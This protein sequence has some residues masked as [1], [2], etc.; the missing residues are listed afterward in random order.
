MGIGMA[1]RG[2]R[3]PTCRMVSWRDGEWNV[4]CDGFSFVIR[5]GKQS[6]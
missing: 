3:S 2:T 4:L 6:G 1:G 5:K